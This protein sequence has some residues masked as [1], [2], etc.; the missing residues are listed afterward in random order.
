G[1]AVFMMLDN[2]GAPQLASLRSRMAAFFARISY[3]LYLVHGPVLILTFLAVRASP[4]IQT[5]GGLLLTAC[6][7]AIS[8]AICW[9][10]YLFIEGPLIRMAHQRFRYVGSNVQ[11]YGFSA[12]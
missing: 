1:S 11:A 2:K 5:A 3:A 7:F 8:V 6:A 4:E 12:R 10:S 9:A